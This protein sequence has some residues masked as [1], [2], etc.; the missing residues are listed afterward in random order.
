[1]GIYQTLRLKS[2]PFS[3]GRSGPTCK[4]SSE[5]DPEVGRVVSVLAGLV[6]KHSIG[7]SGDERPFLAD[8]GNSTNWRFRPGAAIRSCG[9]C[10]GYWSQE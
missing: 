4:R 7:C 6:Y 1:M 9:W 5:T 3:L 8:F 10:C 2:A